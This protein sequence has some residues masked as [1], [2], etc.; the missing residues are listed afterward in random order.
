MLKGKD[1]HHINKKRKIWNYFNWFY[2]GTGKG[3][4]KNHRSLTCNCAYCKS[5]QLRKKQENKENR[6]NSKRELKKLN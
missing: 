1:I 5:E 4:L 6:I 3:F 2:P